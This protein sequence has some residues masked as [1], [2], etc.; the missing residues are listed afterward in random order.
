MKRTIKYL[1]FVISVAFVLFGVFA[2]V[3]VDG[4]DGWLIKVKSEGTFDTSASA[5]PDGTIVK[6]KWDFD[7]GK[8]NA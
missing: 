8:Y 5:D 1:A 4:G 7:D 3:S 6:H 2:G